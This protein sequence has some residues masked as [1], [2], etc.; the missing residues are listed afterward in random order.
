MTETLETFD[1]YGETLADVASYEEYRAYCD[2]DG[3]SFRALG[4]ID[5]EAYSGALADPNTTWGTYQGKQIPLLVSIDYAAGYN[6]ARSRELTQQP[7]TLFLSVP[8]SLL[9][10][11]KP[12]RLVPLDNV[13]VI[14]ET[15]ASEYEAAKQDLAMNPLFQHLQAKE[16]ID[17]TIRQEAQKTAAMSIYQA[18]LIPTVE[19]RS[20]PATSDL[21]SAWQAYLAR[22]EAAGQPVNLDTEARFLTSA[23][24]AQQPELLQELWSICESRFGE[25]GEFH[26]VSMEESRE[27]FYDMLL[28]S[29][30]HTIV[31][32]DE[33][34]PVCFGFFMGDIDKCSWL[35]ESYRDALRADAAAK[36]QSIL[37]YPEIMSR[38]DAQAQSV[39]VISLLTRLVAATHQP[40]RLVFEVTNRSK[41]YIPNLVKRYI[42]STGSME[43]QSD[44]LEVDTLRYWQLNSRAEAGPYTA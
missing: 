26:P 21:E 19:Q 14:V 18:E 43:F 29:K 23:D 32:Y 6:A 5:P 17:P 4:I 13:A 8:Y 44:L 25:L 7:N 15:S 31:K 41:T 11:L 36:Q 40:T 10:V 28:D 12:D 42:E 34:R 24:L 22:R 37:Y 35:S 39:A 3:H 38:K 33:G 1:E 20:H 30:T 27:F 2:R 9:H 16:F